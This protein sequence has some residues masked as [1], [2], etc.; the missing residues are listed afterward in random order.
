MTYLAWN[1]INGSHTMNLVS[2]VYSV[3]CEKYIV[4]ASIESSAFTDEQYLHLVYRNNNNGNIFAHA[5]I[6][7]CNCNDSY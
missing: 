3:K 1:W 4:V 2:A 5:L 7:Y 6:F